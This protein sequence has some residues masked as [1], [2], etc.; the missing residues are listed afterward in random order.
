MNARE[1]R[2]RLLAETTRIEKIG[3]FWIVPSATGKGVYKVHLERQSCSCPDHLELGTVCKHVHA[4][5]FSLTKSE[6]LK[7]GDTVEQTVTVETVVKRKTYKQD[8]PAYNAAQ[9][10]EVRHFSE[11]LHDLC[12]VLPAPAPRPGRPMINPSDAAFCAISKVFSLKSARRFMGELDEAKSEGFIG[13][14]P[15]F[16]SVLNWFDAEG[17]TETLK[18][19]IA[20]TAAPLKAVETQFAVDSTGNSSNSYSRW[21]SEKYGRHE[22]LATWVKLHGLCGTKTHVIAAAEIT[23]KHTH[24][25]KMLPPLV[26]DAATRIRA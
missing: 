9:V 26:E 20:R 22:H 10:G 18:E 4:V 19:F 16:N 6:T 11:L 17:T 1:E 12:S 8:W 5:K 15:H 13:H 14:V 3:A 24:D 23:D 2:G 25:T 21:Y 7:N